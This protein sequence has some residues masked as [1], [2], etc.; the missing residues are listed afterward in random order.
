MS[1]PTILTRRL[2]DE[3]HKNQRI[4]ELIAAGNTINEVAVIIFVSPDTIKKRLEQIRTYYGV[5]SNTEL[6]AKLYTN[7]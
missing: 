4:I 2:S 1:K 7:G 3:L 5:K 6:I